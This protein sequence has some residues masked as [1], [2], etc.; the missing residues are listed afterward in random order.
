[1]GEIVLYWNWIES[2]GKV[3]LFYG[4][5]VFLVKFQKLAMALIGEGVG[6]FINF[7][8]SMHT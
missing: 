2:W 7:E 6:I 4:T 1:M 5:E 3:W 8:V